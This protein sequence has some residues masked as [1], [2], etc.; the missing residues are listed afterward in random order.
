MLQES[1]FV[2]IERYK[3]CA[4]TVSENFIQLLLA[5]P[6]FIATTAGSKVFHGSSEAIY[7]RG[8]Y[9]I[10]ASAAVVSLPVFDHWLH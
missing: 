10:I 5:I 3:C 6:F 9:A 7:R 8:A 1:V 4:A 2:P